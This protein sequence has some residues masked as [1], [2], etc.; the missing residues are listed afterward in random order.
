MSALTR[1]NVSLRVG[2]EVV[3]AEREQVELADILVVEVVSPRQSNE[4]WF[5]AVF[6]HELVELLSDVIH[7]NQDSY[8]NI[9]LV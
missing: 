4:Q 6:T 1:P 3:G 9:E 5:V 7:F 2:K 8:F